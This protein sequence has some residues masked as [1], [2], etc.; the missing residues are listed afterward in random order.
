MVLHILM[1]VKKWQRSFAGIYCRTDVFRGIRTV[2]YSGCHKISNALILLSFLFRSLV[3]HIFFCRWKNSFFHWWTCIAKFCDKDPSLRPV[4]Q[5]ESNWKGEFTLLWSWFSMENLLNTF[6]SFYF[7][8]FWSV[9]LF[10]LKYWFYKVCKHYAM[11]WVTIFFWR[12]SGY[13]LM[14]YVSTP[15]GT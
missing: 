6:F 2:L 14:V 7:R 15:I 1:P 9:I 3:R 13:S 12:R 4:C 8:E 10:Y 5:I 11:T